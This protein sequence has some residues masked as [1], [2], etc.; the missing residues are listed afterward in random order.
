MHNHRVQIGWKKTSETVR[1]GL[2]S[3]EDM[4]IFRRASASDRDD[5]SN[6]LYYDVRVR[7]AIIPC[8]FHTCLII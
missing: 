1:P 7:V 5:T 3:S 6:A 2:D 4:A 8:N